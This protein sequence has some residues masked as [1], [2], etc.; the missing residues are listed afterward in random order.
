MSQY[1][2]ILLSARPDGNPIG[3]H[4]FEVVSKDIPQ[5][6]AGELLVKQTHMSM[7]PAMLGWM[8]G[9]CVLTELGTSTIVED[10]HPPS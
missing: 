10:A 8:M 6:A 2:E 7:D 5:P 3:P 1:K 4:L 9:W